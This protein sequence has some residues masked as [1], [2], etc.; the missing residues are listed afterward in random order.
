MMTALLLTA[1][2]TAAT[3]IAGGVLLRELRG[4][5]A[6]AQSARAALAACPQTVWVDYRVSEVKVLRS[7]AKVLVLPVKPV[8]SRWATP[9]LRAAA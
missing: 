5:G 8:V 3:L 2:F 9:E 6:A 1:L 7:P 4:I